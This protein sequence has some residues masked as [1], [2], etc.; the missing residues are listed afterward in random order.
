[1]RLKQGITVPAGADQLGR[2]LMQL[3]NLRGHRSAPVTT[4][5]KWVGETEG[6]LR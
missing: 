6:Q 1:M 3:G 2:A 4:Y 5:L